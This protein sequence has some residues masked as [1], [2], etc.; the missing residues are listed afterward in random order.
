MPFAAVAPLTYI[1]S[2]TSRALVAPLL[3][4]VACSGAEPTI[5][6]QPPA[7]TTTGSSSSA[8]LPSAQPTTDA[9]FADS[10][11]SGDASKPARPGYML[12]LE[13]GKKSTVVQGP[14]GAFSHNT[15]QSRD[16]YDF[17]LAND[18]PLVAA[19]DGTVTHVRGDVRPGNPCY[20]G[21]GSSCANTVNYVTIAHADGTSTLY[22]HVNQPL[23]TVGQTVR[24]GERIALSGGTGWSTGPHAHV[25]RQEKCGIWICNSTPLTFV[26]AGI[27]KTGTAVTSANCP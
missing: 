6:P 21:G 14:G 2:M 12:P 17:D 4:V 25:Q 5:E 20:S 8:P 24:R 19:N 9:G 27:P 7:P 16:A 10:G 22:L 11:G 1:S 18:T 23:V 15:A 26:E 13:C 3:L